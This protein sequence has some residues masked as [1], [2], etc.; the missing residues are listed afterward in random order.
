MYTTGTSST[1]VETPVISVIMLAFFA[2][3][4]AL[5]SSL[6]LSSTMDGPGIIFPSISLLLVAILPFLKVFS[7]TLQLNLSTMPVNNFTN[8]RVIYLY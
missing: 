3:A 8:Q 2:A 4:A 6:N 5:W 7:P 1:C